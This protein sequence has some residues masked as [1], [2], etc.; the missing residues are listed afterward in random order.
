MKRLSL[1]ILLF[2]NIFTLSAK[3]GHW[4]KLG[5]FRLLTEISI[6]V[7][8]DGQLGELHIGAHDYVVEGKNIIKYRDALTKLRDKYV[9]WIAVAHENNIRSLRKDVNV[10]FPNVKSHYYDYIEL[11]VGYHETN[12]PA[13]YEFIVDN[14]E[15][16]MMGSQSPTFSTLSDLDE[17]L[18]ILNNIEGIVQAA[19][20]S[21]Q[22]EKQNRELFY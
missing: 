2:L 15:M 7:Y 22:E 9:D 4:C 12:R 20:A 18:S 6:F 5:K 10:I 11:Q 17:F 16:W 8:D 3:E 13:K 1:L 14:S 19:T 21:M